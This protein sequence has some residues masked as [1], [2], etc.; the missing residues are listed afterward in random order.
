MSIP[1]MSHWDS[2]PLQSPA[3]LLGPLLLAISLNGWNWTFHSSSRAEVQKGWRGVVRVPLLYLHSTQ[4]LGSTTSS[5]QVLHISPA[6]SQR[7]GKKRLSLWQLYHV[8]AT[9]QAAGHSEE[10]CGSV[11]PQASHPS[12]GGL[13]HTHLPKEEEGKQEGEASPHPGLEA[14]CKG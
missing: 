3:G 11:P 14:L 10:W 13:V 1:Q 5:T 12:P 9:A 7:W 8:P 4:A 6:K 2:A